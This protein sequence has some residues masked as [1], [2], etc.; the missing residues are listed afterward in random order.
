M[1][2]VTPTPKNIADIKSNLLRPALTSHF[3]VTIPKPGGG[4]DSFLKDNGVILNQE[5]LNLMCSEAVLPGSNLAT[6]EI[7][8]NFHG[9]TERHAYRR[10]Y[11]DRIDLT[12]YVD[13]DNYLPIRYFE[14]WMKYIVDESM[15]T[16]DKGAGCKDLSV[17]IIFIELDILREQM[18]I[19]HL[20]V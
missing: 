20:T 3:A 2:S 8:D 12:F 15:R 18:D 17:V 5:K 7:N 9:V 1:P 11:D 4:F 14:T 19:L 13:A 6:F 16:Q 10:V